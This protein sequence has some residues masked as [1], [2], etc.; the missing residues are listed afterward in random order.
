MI[1]L[2]KHQDFE[3]I[4]YDAHLTMRAVCIK[5]GVAPNLFYAWKAGRGTPTLATLQKL[6]DVLNSLSAE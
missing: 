3:A 1:I 4:A 5:A 6:V 2:P